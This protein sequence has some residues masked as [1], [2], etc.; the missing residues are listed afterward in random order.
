MKKKHTPNPPG[1]DLNKPDK[2]VALPAPTPE[3]LRRMIE[4]TK[5]IV[6]AET[7]IRPDVVLDIGVGD[8]RSEQ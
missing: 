3:E 4:R 7:G 8:M 6:E 5:D 2:H 1:P